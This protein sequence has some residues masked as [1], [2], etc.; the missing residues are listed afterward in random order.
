MSPTIPQVRDEWRLKSSHDSPTFKFD[1][2]GDDIFSFRAANVPL[3]GLY[4]QV[5]R[6]ANGSV[7]DNTSA[8]DCVTI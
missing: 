4:P 8:A 1:T 7:R 6:G 3:A 5:G 2:S